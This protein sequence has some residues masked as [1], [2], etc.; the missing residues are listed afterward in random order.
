M[1]TR[2]GQLGQDNWDRIAMAGTVGT[3]QPGQDNRYRTA[4]VGQPGQ[5]SWNSL[6]GTGK[7]GLNDQDR[8]AVAVQPRQESQYKA[9]YFGMKL[10]SQDTLP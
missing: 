5:D 9:G 7:L 2:K 8:R 10:V 1:T 3:G 6:A 4:E